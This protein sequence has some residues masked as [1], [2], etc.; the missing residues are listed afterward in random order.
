MKPALVRPSRPCYVQRSQGAKFLQ[1]VDTIRL[2]RPPNIHPVSYISGMQ[3][4]PFRFK[5]AE[6]LPMAED[7]SD[8]RLR[9]LYP[10]MCLGALHWQPLTGKV[11]M[12]PYVLYTL[13]A[14]VRVKTTGLQDSQPS[15]TRAI[16]I[17]P[18]VPARPP[19]YTG[20]FPEEYS[21]RSVAR[22]RTHLCGRRIGT[23]ELSADE[24]QPI[25]LMDSSPRSSTIV[26][27]RLSF[28][29]AR[30]VLGHAIEPYTWGFRI[31]TRL[32]RRVFYTT[33][34]FDEEPTL[35]DARRKQYVGLHTHVLQ[36]EEREY[37]ELP[38]RIG[39]TAPNGTILSANEQLSSWLL[40]IPIMFTTKKSLIPS[41]L[42]AAVA[43]RYSVLL[44]VRVIGPWTL[45]AP[46]EIPLQVTR[47]SQRTG[48]DSENGC[49]EATEPPPDYRRRVY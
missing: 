48:E 31:R 36:S 12:Q 7:G 8:P 6:R 16:A 25:N 29:P 33:R 42:T 44:D 24:P 38:W 10:S 30:K 19:I 47:D 9:E 22:V 46:L 41:C 23:L 45:P 39:H 2:Q 18:R 21:L 5:I 40:M 15:T 4:A 27:L 11:S 28:E 32:Q 1:Q 37:L 3:R 34:S 26:V 20:A 14:R 49:S 43:V 13:T 35:V 17:M